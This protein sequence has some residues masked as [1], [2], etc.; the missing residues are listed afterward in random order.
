MTDVKSAS[1][2]IGR[3]FIEARPDILGI[4]ATLREAAHLLGNSGGEMFAKL[5]RSVDAMNQLADLDAIA[6]ACGHDAAITGQPR[7]WSQSDEWHRG[8]L[9][10]KLQRH[11]EA[12]LYK[13]IITS[14]NDY[15]AVH[16]SATLD[17]CLVA[18]KMAT[19]S[20]KESNEATGK[21]PKT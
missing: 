8:Y 19:T 2:A 3:A 16:T 15:L 21:K 1:D 12:G 11:N 13:A 14:V 20:V 18:L 5:N 4:M 9:A 10:G 17:E 6:N 7:D